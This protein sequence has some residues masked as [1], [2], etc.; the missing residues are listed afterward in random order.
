MHERELFKSHD[1]QKRSQALLW[2]VVLVI[3]IGCPPLMQN[4][5][6]K[7]YILGPNS[8]KMRKLMKLSGVHTTKEYVSLPR[9]P[10]VRN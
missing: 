5:G 8:T 7:N 6:I 1:P 9:I 10:S 4:F 2:V 3:P